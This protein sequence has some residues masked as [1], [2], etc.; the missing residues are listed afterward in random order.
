MVHHVIYRYGINSS[1]VFGIANPHFPI[2]YTAVSIAVDLS[3]LHNNV[4]ST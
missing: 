3:S 2:Y 1:H 4:F